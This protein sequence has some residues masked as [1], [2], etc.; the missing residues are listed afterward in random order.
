MSISPIDVEDAIDMTRTIIAL[1]CLI[2]TV[3]LAGYSHAVEFDC[4][5]SAKLSAIE[6]STDVEYR[7]AAIRDVLAHLA[8]LYATH[9]TG[10]HSLEFLLEVDADADDTHD[11]AELPTTV[12]LLLRQPSFLD[13]LS[14]IVEISGVEFRFAE[15]AVIFTSQNPLDR[16]HVS[17]EENA[18]PRYHIPPV[19]H[20][21]QAAIDFDVA[22]RYAK[23]AQ[24]GLLSLPGSFP[25]EIE[26]RLAQIRSAFLTTNQETNVIVRL[27][28]SG[29]RPV[30]ISLR[31]IDQDASE[32]YEVS[33]EQ[34]L[35]SESMSSGER[36]YGFIRVL[37]PSLWPRLIPPALYEL[38]VSCNFDTEL[39]SGE[40]H[41]FSVNRLLRLVITEP[42]PAGD[43][44]VCF[45]AWLYR[46]YYYYP[47][48][49]SASEQQRGQDLEEALREL[50]S[51]GFSF[52][53]IM[54]D[55]RVIGLAALKVGLHD[56][57]YAYLS[58]YIARYL[59]QPPSSSIDDVHDV[60]YSSVQRFRELCREEGFVDPYADFDDWDVIMRN[61]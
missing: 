11:D 31:T 51:Q 32:T 55:D 30:R 6:I 58:A 43:N 56:I 53:T 48:I 21:P 44:R 26:I 47:L 40:K 4:A 61:P 10:D 37:D 12:T 14:A 34:W 41:S 50:I 33:E 36:L 35:I 5:T 59:D 39:D 52:E 18:L 17:L 22:V 19:V 29:E 15:D 28:L 54:D 3:V 13:L 2:R 7:N 45:M 23:P 46:L 25:L 38:D 8:R 1:C 9:S 24:D 20:S 49:W 42:V 27:S 16:P 57:A 60:F